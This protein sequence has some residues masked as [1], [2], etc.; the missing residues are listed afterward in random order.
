M[1]STTTTANIPTGPY[2][3]F[4]SKPVFDCSLNT[5][6]GCVQGRKKHKKW[7]TVLIDNDTITKVKGLQDQ[8]AKHKTFIL[9]NK[10]TGEMVSLA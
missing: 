3:V 6:S 2:S 4:M 9:R 7:K 10:S 1:E 5:F 8:S